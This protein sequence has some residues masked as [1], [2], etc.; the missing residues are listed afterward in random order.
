MNW[1]QAQKETIETRDKN[2]LVSAAAGS[3]KTAVLIERIRQLIIRDKVDIDRFLITTFTNAAAAE[4]KERLEKSIRAA[5][6]EEGADRAFLRRQLELMP[7]ANI[8][9]FHTFALD[10]M[11]RYFYL[12]DLEPGFRIG[13]DIQ[14]SIMKRDAADELFERRFAGDSGDFRAFLRK[15]SSDRN[16]KRIKEN[17]IAMYNEM[18]SVPDYME[19]AQEHAALLRESSPATALGITDVV[20]E[21]TRQGIREAEAYYRRALELLREQE[22]TALGDKAEADCRMLAWAAEAAEDESRLY[23]DVMSFLRAPGFSQMRA[24]KAEKEKYELIKD[25]VSALRKKGKGIIDDLVKRYFSRTL[26]EYEE[27]IASEYEDT[28]YFIGLVREFEDIFRESKQ[29]RNMVDFD[30]V[31]HYAIRILDDDMAA[32][33]Y[34]DSFDYI[35]IDEFQDSNMLQE[36]IIQRIAG[37]NNL[38]MVGDVKQS[39]YKFRLAEPEIFRQKYALYKDP[40]TKESVKID[41]NSNFRSKRR[42]ADTVNAVFEDVMEDYDEDAKLHCGVDEQYQGYET[43][44]HIIEKGTG[45][46]PGAADPEIRLV[47]RLIKQMLGKTIYDVKRGTERPVEYGDIAVLSRN[48]ALIGDVEK[49]LNNEGIPACGENTGGYFETVE[50]KVFLNILRIIDNTR[51]D[52]PLISVMRCPVF[53]FDPKELAAVRIA[54]EGG[55]YYDAVRSYAQEGQD[56]ALR[57]KVADML[58]RIDLWKEIKQTIPLGELVR[59]LIYDTGY[60]DYCSGLPAGKQR[61]ANLRMLV[62]KA[63]AFEE[64]SY[65][66]LYGFLS[67]VEAMEKNRIST[68]EAKLAGSGENAVSIMTVHKSKGL[69]FPVVILM[70]AGRAIRF[71][72][73]GSPAAMHKD[74]GISLPFVN[75]EEKWHR[76]TLLQ[77]A[78][79]GRKSR[80]ELEEEVRILYV[81][82]TRAMDCLIV[83]AS[84]RDTGSL[85]ESID[86]K[87]SYLDMMYGALR[88]THQ[89]IVVYE[90]TEQEEA[91]ASSAAGH[92]AA[93]ERTEAVL[94]RAAGYSDEDILEKIDRKLSFVYPYS[95][96]G[97]VKSK[98]SVT[99]LNKG[100]GGNICDIHLNT[101]A[102]SAE[103]K[104]LSAA[105]IGTAMHLVME[106]M[107]FRKALEEGEDYVRK[108]ADRLYENGILEKEE[109]AVINT[110]NI[111]A[112]F[113]AETGKRAA[114]SD[115][116]YREREFILQKEVNGTDAIVQGIIDCYFEED[117]G[118]VLIDYKNSYMGNGMTEEKIADRY[119]NQIELYKEALE[120]ASGRIVREAYMYLF[121]MKKFIKIQ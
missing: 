8:S 46:V 106:T 73:T 90:N 120:A 59:R 91:A 47:C 11:R 113:E 118:I 7:S 41:L 86:R 27:E 6:K 9:T 107:D 114:L 115:R 43:S 82:M 51:Q 65:T 94:Q 111:A 21:E 74:L 37:E 98:Y 63:E 99:E 88:R 112:F 110:E 104:K 38:F 29:S 67:Y 96:Q 70:G 32:A 48:R 36:R 10:V 80:E 68:G 85:E 12:T 101:P 57:E 71:K 28:E 79:E 69:E 64:S 20:L 54:S 77:R 61:I 34:R 60:Y 5:L 14:V 16:E 95:V 26:E 44:L 117:D 78:I 72:G 62:E 81:A 102:F 100:E 97:E 18:R 105:E 4:M 75:R 108:F 23:T 40:E 39:I 50:V 2:I 33:E 30:D 3:G 58:T 55:S 19:W 17:I 109:R 116:L 13:D 76:K 25:Q 89:K 87:K 31:M 121:D 35:F 53:G 84:V 92:L 93:R 56:E 66:G 119:R 103:E 45:S 83:T 1:T 42:I 49:Y 22:L 52:I 24:G 15:Y